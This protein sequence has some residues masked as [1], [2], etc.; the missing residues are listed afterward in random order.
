MKPEHARCEASIGRAHRAVWQAW[1]AGT[2]LGWDGLTLDL[3]Q[4][5]RELE[6]IQTDLLANN[7]PKRIRRLATGD[8]ASPRSG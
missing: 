5:L 7:P 6:R 8:A 2:M 4:V 1:E 3:E